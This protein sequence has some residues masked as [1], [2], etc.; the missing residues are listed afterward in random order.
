MQRYIYVI[1]AG[2][3]VY[4]VGLATNVEKRLR[5]LQTANPQK[6]FV[7]HRYPT[8]AP[9]RMEGL[10]HDLLKDHLVL[11]EWFRCDLA[12]IEE[13]IILAER[14]RPR[15]RDASKGA[16]WKVLPSTT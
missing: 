10:I 3:G 11:G 15:G 16:S 12:D 1:G 4:K 14:I 2:D 5:G 9:F 6:L 13:A 8:T 7:F